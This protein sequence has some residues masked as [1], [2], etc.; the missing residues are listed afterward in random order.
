[1]GRLWG[2]KSNFLDIVAVQD[3][4]GRNSEFN[5]SHLRNET[6]TKLYHRQELLQLIVDDSATIVHYFSVVCEGD[7]E[8]GVSQG[9]CT[10]IP[11]ICP[12]GATCLHTFSSKLSAAVL[13]C[14]ET[15]S[16]VVSP[17]VNPVV[18]TASCMMSLHKDIQTS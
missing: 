9:F 10:Y 3:L 12:P 17:T 4:T 5:E 16:S 1:M 7:T 13:V 8:Q 6:L 18:Y 2:H 15:T 11:R 14:M